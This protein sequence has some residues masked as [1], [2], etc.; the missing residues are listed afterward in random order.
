MMCGVWTDTL[1]ELLPCY[2]SKYNTHRFGDMFGPRLQASS[3]W[4]SYH[5]V[6]TIDTVIKPGFWNTGEPGYNDI[7]LYDTSSLASDIP[8]YEWSPQHYTPRL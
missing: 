8:C 3:F 7:G 2:V 1:F 5:Y 6:M 4:N